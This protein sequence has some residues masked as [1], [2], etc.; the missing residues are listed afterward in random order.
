TLQLHPINRQTAAMRAGP[1]VS[2]KLQHPD[3]LLGAGGLAAPA[4]KETRMEQ[5]SQELQ[6]ELPGEVPE[7]WN[8]LAVDGDAVHGQLGRA[9][10]EVDVLRA[11]V[12]ALAVVL[13]DQGGE[14]IAERDVARR[15][16]V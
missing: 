11:H 12:G 9:D 13:L 10:H 1:R 14:A 5:R 2:V 16:L 15:I 3:S 7:H 4:S 6:L 8:A